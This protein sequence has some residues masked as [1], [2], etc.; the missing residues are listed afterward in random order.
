MGAYRQ[1]GLTVMQLLA[2]VGAGEAGSFHSIATTTLSTAQATVTFSSI[3][4]T[5]KHLQVRVLVKTSAGGSLYMTVNSTGATKNH[6]LRGDGS[7]AYSAVTA[8]NFVLN[9]S[10]SAFTAGIIDI[11]DYTNTNKLRVSRSIGGYDA[12]GSGEVNLGSGF[13]NISTVVSSLSFSMT[14]G[15][16]TSLSSLAL[17]GIAG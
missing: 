8:G 5:F 14:S 13:Y 15:N 1:F 17:Y 10:T 3:P 6:Q 16:I 9:T 11:L 2:G 12:N 7:T 4:A